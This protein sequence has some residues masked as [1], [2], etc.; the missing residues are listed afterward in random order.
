MLYTRQTTEEDN[1]QMP[2]TSTSYMMIVFLNCLAMFAPLFHVYAL[3]RPF[4]SIKSFIIRLKYTGVVTLWTDIDSPCIA[5]QEE[6][7]GVRW[8]II[9]PP[10]LEDC[11][12]DIHTCRKFSAK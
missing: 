7:E 3:A 1:N 9:I 5:A 6:H 8:K 11:R 4:F 12:S 10:D 2:P